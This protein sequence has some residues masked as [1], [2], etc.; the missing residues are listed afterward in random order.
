MNRNHSYQ[1]KS[2]LTFHFGNEFHESSTYHLKTPRINVLKPQ[3]LRPF[4]TEKLPKND[5]E[6]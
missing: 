6:K 2:D 3:D 4:L 5:D 1:K